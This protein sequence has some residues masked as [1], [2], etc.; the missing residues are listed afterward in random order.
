[1]Q[2]LRLKFHNEKV[3]AV[4][5]ILP[6]QRRSKNVSTLSGDE[7]AQLIVDLMT[8]PQVKKATSTK[9]D[10]KPQLRPGEDTNLLRLLFKTG[11]ARYGKMFDSVIASK[12]MSSIAS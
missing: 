10:G 3:G 12:F 4:Q 2:I 7:I 5:T 6:K 9:A 8:L 11:Y 1:M